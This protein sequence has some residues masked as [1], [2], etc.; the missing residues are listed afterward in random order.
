LKSVKSLLLLLYALYGGVLKAQQPYAYQLANLQTDVVYNMHQD[1][2]GF[3]WLA[4]NK[5]LARYDGYEY[6]NFRSDRQTSAAGSNIQEDDYGRIWY[7]NFDGFLYY[8]KNNTLHTFKQNPPT[9]FAG[10][11]FTKNYLF[12]VQSK[13]VDVYNLSSLSLV[14][15]LTFTFDIAESSTVFNNSF[16]FIADNIFYKISEN[17]DVIKSTF[18]KDKNL[19]IKY[20]FPYK[21][22]QL[23]VAS[24]LNE[25][26]EMYFFDSNL[27][28]NYAIP[29]P[30]VSYIQGSNVI[31]NNIWLHSSNG[32]HVYERFG[33]K[34][35]KNAL[36]PEKSSSKVIR[37]HQN[38]YWFSSVNNG[39][40][41]AP[42]LNHVVFQ[43]D[44]SDF[45][46][47][48]QTDSGYIFGTENGEIIYTD[49][50]F[51]NKKILRSVGEKVPSYYVYYDAVDKQAIVSDIGFTVASMTNFNTKTT[52]NAALKDA[53]KL[54][55]KYYAI[56]VS[57]F[58]GLLRNPKASNTI[59]SIWDATF[60]KYQDKDVPS[61]AKIV[62]G[63]RGKSVD[64]LDKTNEIAFATNVGLYV[65]STEGIKEIK[66]NNESVY[67]ENVLAINNLLY[68]LDTKGYLSVLNTKYQFKKLN[69]TQNI[70]D[71]TIRLIRKSNNNLLIIGTNYIYIFNAVDNTYQKVDFH[72][73]AGLINDIIKDESNL[74]ILTNDAV[75]RV[76]ITDNKTYRNHWFHI[77]SFAINHTQRSWQK[78]LKLSYDENNVEIKFSV[79]SYFQKIP[80]VYYRINQQEWVAVH[81][82][83]RSVS[84]PSLS[85]G[86][87]TMQFKVGN[88]IIADAIKFTINPPFWKTW[89][90][91]LLLT[92]SFSAMV[93]M[94]FTRKSYI[95]RRQIKLL[96][97]KVL[98]E[99]NLSKSVMASI[100]SQMNPHFFYNALNTIQ[101]YIFTNDKQKAN[102]Y[103]AKFSKLT[104]LILEMSEKEKVSLVEEIDALTLYLELEKMRFNTGFEYSFEFNLQYEKESIEFPPMLIQ[105]YIENAIKHGLLHKEGEKTLKISFKQLKNH[106]EVAIIDNGIGRKRSEELNKIKNE[107]HQSFST[108]ANEKRLEI[109][110]KGMQNKMA[111][112]ILD[113]YN[114]YG[115]ATG[116]TVIL[117]IPL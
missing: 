18:F 34:V 43:V 75:I 91:Y 9:G 115:L 112:K 20:V 65:I 57:G 59:S 4:T 5:G 111:V 73:Q 110:N 89:W 70:P 35:Y 116:T 11:G 94:Y 107:K 66:N 49:K 29:I 80:Q 44:D 48:A 78:P 55:D 8:V 7:Q 81:K 51:S 2:K 24:K 17:F 82:E 90:F 63:V 32:V 64:Y 46:R 72:I 98:L 38:N 3:I 101:A 21:N 113:R 52:F 86:S 42:N 26:K 39:V 58:C 33:K 40:N 88:T 45:L 114:D 37:D 83:T 60:K 13:G 76:P 10:Y 54:D 103:L 97:E 53:V 84:F 109:L 95:M 74:I 28:F 22:K 12:V 56:T 104:R 27:R 87:Y 47:F 108:Q 92:V 71:E 6:K 19:H 15:T 25:T 69:A 30:D 61:F 62:K 16:Y 50:L 79:L 117:S 36:F 102:N 77:N 100:K 1:A 31:D 99:K 23:Y 105:P 96:N 41:V 93:Y 68:V 67:A 106:L 85:A 14:K